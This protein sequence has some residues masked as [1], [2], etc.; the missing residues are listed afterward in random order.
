[1]QVRGLTNYQPASRPYKTMQI[2]RK[3]WKQEYADIPWSA[4]S[5]QR[6]QKVGEIPVQINKPNPSKT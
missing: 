3:S 6:E 5:F 4:G 1:M 2:R